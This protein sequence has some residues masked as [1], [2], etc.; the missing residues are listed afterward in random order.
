MC[1]REEQKDK[2][3]KEEESSLVLNDENQKGKT[4][5]NRNKFKSN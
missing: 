1:A 5:N 2:E 3:I 4:K